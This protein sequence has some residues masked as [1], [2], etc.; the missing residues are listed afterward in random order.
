MKCTSDIKESKL[1]VEMPVTKLDVIKCK[2]FVVMQR[3]ETD[4]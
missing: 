4:K 2:W 1:V 3:V